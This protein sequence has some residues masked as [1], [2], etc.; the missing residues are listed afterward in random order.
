MQNSNAKKSNYKKRK[1]VAPEGSGRQICKILPQ[2]CPSSQTHSTTHTLSA[3]KNAY[4][5]A[6]LSSCTISASKNAIS[7]AEPRLRHN[8]APKNAFFVAKPRLRH[9]SAPKNAIFV[10]KPH[11]GNIIQ[12]QLLCN[13]EHRIHKCFI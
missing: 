1:K 3:S 10:A 12:Q 6:K 5:I 13:R 11:P 4:F 7:V 8:S 9:N 2:N